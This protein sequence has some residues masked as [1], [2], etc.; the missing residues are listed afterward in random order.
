MM[1]NATKRKFAAYLAGITVIAGLMYV[2]TLGGS[3]INAVDT[4]APQLSAMDR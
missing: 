4:R 3:T 1:I 2:V